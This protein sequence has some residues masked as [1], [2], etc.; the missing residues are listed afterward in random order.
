LARKKE[1]G[2]RRKEEGNGPLG[3]FLVVRIDRAEARKCQPFQSPQ[4]N[5]NGY[6]DL[7]VWQKSIN[8]VVLTYRSTRR[9]PKHELF[10]ITQQIQ[11]AAV[12]VPANIAEGHGRTTKG[13]YRNFVSVARGSL[14]ELETLL[15]I[16]FHL[17]YLPAKATRN[18]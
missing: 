7:K 6:R 4:M 12:S 11:R 14:K 18:C 1:E 3:V 17:G 15:E 10:G 16:A 9:F 2:G 8:L 5:T 13:E